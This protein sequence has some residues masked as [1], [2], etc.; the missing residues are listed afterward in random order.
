[1]VCAS[2]GGKL[3]LDEA[4][5]VPFGT[6]YRCQPCTVTAEVD[7]HIRRA[8][9]NEEQQRGSRYDTRNPYE[10]SV[11]KLRREVD[12]IRAR[13][14]QP[15]DG[16][17]PPPE[18]LE[19]FLESDDDVAAETAAKPLGGLDD[20]PPPSQPIEIHSAA[21]RYVCIGCF[22]HA[23]HRPGNCPEDEV[24][25]SDLHNREVIDE[26]R[27][28]V[29][30]RANRREGT[31]FAICLSLAFVVGFPIGIA[32]EPAG[33]HYYRDSPAVF[34]TIVIFALLYGLSRWLWKPLRVRNQVAD[35]LAAVGV[36]VR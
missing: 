29:K 4:D 19:P 2:C 24:A 5:V 27:A 10:P 1:M 35:L 16:D 17:V 36:D 32:F 8:E 3:P 13:P 15:G 23:S 18:V 6:G 34:L 9:I 33:H 26:L 7:V 25:L 22:R 30:R 31:R 14:P 28:F 20:G 21:P 12:A 11:E